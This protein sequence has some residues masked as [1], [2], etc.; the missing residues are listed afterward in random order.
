MSARL[1]GAALG[2]VLVA[3]ACGAEG[4]RL[5]AP[6]ASVLGPVT[7]TRTSEL[8]VAALA[9]DAREEGELTVLLEEAGV[10][11]AVER[12][13]TAGPAIRRLQVRIVRFETVEGA[14][15]Y[16]MW[17]DA[18][19]EEIIGGAE[20]VSGPEAPETAS[21][22]V[23]AADPCCPKETNVTL[24]A[25]RDGA[26]VIRVLMAGPGADAAATNDVVADVR[27]WRTG[28]P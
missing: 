22:F 9:A 10:E 27:G 23:H 15:T 12:W 14:E 26:E 2:L 13:F 24:A 18:H 3:T 16:V 8:D 25:W 17:L 7:I 11:D 1:F 20:A 28:S 4:G 5:A 6:P 19:V 21:L